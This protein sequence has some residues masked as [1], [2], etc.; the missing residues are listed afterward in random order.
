MQVAISWKF[1]GLVD[2]ENNPLV[3]FPITIGGGFQIFPLK[4]M[5]AWG[6]RQQQQRN[7]VDIFGT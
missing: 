7:F 6:I 5:T 1:L 4:I 3:A 2:P